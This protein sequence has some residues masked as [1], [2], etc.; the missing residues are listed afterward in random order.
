MNTTELSGLEMAEKLI[1]RA[2]PA[3]SMA[4][5]IPMQLIEVEKGFAKF[6]SQASD[7][8]LNPMGTVH[9]GF[10][11]TLLD[12]ATGC[13]VLTTL[14]SGDKYAT[15]DLNVKMLK[16]IP[17]GVQLKALG[18]VIHQS[19]RLSVAEGK[20]V[21]SDGTLYAHA[22]AICMILRKKER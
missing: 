17:L 15:I 1:S 12:S 2:I 11:A 13:A 22:T 20:I 18:S 8:F 21:D 3:P 5:A 9:G 14:D 6:Y 16:H 7:S 19:R 10:S 4:S